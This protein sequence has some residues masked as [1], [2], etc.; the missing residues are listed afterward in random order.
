MEIKKNWIKE[1]MEV[2]HKDNPEVRMYVDEII[3]QYQ[4][5]KEQDK[6][7]NMQD[8]KKTRI[9]GVKVHWWED[10]KMRMHRLHTSL[11]VPWEVAAKGYTEILKYLDKYHKL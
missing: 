6:D 11:L 1:G 8:V 7:G 9:K 10:G 3:I 5:Q 4:D 2:A